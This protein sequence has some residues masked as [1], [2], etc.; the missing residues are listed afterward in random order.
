MTVPRIIERL[1]RWISGTTTSNN[2]TLKPASKLA[3]MALRK[4]ELSAMLSALLSIGQLLTSS[5]KRAGQSRL[6]MVASHQENANTRNEQQLIR[7]SK[8]AL[9]KDTLLVI[10]T[11]FQFV[12][13][14]VLLIDSLRAITWEVIFG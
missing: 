6:G 8:I 14:L 11:L 13:A 1:P 7:M 5:I 3:P 12:V 4:R 10:N 2:S 9:S